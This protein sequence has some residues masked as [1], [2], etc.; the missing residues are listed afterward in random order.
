MKLFSFAYAGGDGH[1]F[2]PLVKELKSCNV[3]T[4][5]FYYKGRGGRQDEGHYES[6][7]EIA[8]ETADF[9]EKHE[10]SDGYALLGHS[11]G[12]IVA[13][14]CYYELKRRGV[15]L[16]C[17]IYFS[18]SLP[19]DKLIQNRFVDEDDDGFID[20]LK[21]LGGMDP[22]VLEI[23]EF[24]NFFLPIIKHDIKI[25]EEYVFEEK[26]EKISVPVTILTGSLDEVRG[27]KVE[28]WKNHAK[29]EPIFIELDGDHFFIFN[30]KQD[31]KEIFENLIN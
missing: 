23:P 6:I 7:M 25:Y 28:G 3:T 26:D 18:G 24:S 30:E 29:I 22:K 4:I 21:E 27:E 16:P 14:E 5:P 1:V 15:Q 13:Y 2:Y 12:S 11:M 8:V 19:P 31:Y 20:K 9:I 10:V 17:A